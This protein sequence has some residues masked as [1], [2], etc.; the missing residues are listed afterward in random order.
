MTD[1]AFPPTKKGMNPSIFKS[2]FPEYTGIFQLSIFTD[3]FVH[4][5]ASHIC[6]WIPGHLQIPL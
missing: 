2:T 3:K 1:L 5:Y 4:T 6:G